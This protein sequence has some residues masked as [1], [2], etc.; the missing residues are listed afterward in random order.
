MI[1]GGAFSGC[2]SLFG[3]LTF[4]ASIT[5]IEESYID[6]SYTGSNFSNCSN[7][8]KVDLSA[9]VD[10]KT[11]AK[12]AF[13]SCRNVETVILPDSL[14][15]I[16]Q[17]A[18][19]SCEK[20]V[21]LN[22]PAGLTSINDNAFNY[23]KSLRV[24]DFSKSVNLTSIGGY[25]FDYCSALETVNVPES[26]NY[27]GSY[28][29]RECRALTNLTVYGKTPA[30]LGEYAFRRVNTDVCAL[31]I[32]TSSF[33]DYLT[34][35]QWGAFVQMR[36][37]I[38][39][40][41]D[42]GAAMTYINNASVNEDD[43]NAMPTTRSSN[44]ADLQGDAVVK[45]G[46]S[47]YVK[48]NETVS[49]FIH[50]EENVMIKQVFFNEE[51]VTAQVVNNVFTT[52]QVEDKSSLRVTLTSSGPIAVQRI[53]LNHEE[54]ILKIAESAQLIATVLP[55]NAT[56]KGVIW[57]SSNEQ[58]A[59]VSESGRV[60]ALKAG[61]A[62]ITAISEEGTVTAS[63]ALTV[64]SN[65]YYFYADDV[66]A[67]VNTSIKMPVSMY[68]ENEVT[69]FQFD[70]YC[71]EGIEITSQW[72]H[73]PLELSY[74]SGMHTVS[75]AKQSNGSVRF[76]IYSKTND[77]FSGNDGVLFYLPLTITDDR[78]SY[79]IELK[80]IHVSGRNAIDFTLPDMTTR[81]IVSEYELGDSNDSKRL[82][83]S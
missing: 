68:N 19:S 81:V 78:G 3:T 18:F 67:F 12:Y 40:M 61:N 75:A 13:S 63:C 77:A 56:N 64:L 15:R 57:T 47:V 53:E 70:A 25:A 79:L 83:K 50:P 76:V 22:F 35:A 60:Q 16:E 36:K 48:K 17:Y 65:N 73:Y 59:T 21:D 80:N 52:P 9:C 74:R 1:G 32:P 44:M 28:A 71:P 66:P 34:A 29:F 55:R 26:V 82:K 7:I 2:S 49:F 39:V 38:D 27:I 6:Y 4:P 30:Q 8:V 58:V 33:Y 14:Q 45:D 62:V 42:E 72:G 23:C 10:L 54:L 41:L 43:E 5:A 46:S 51:D 11:L 37:A 20:L 31:T 69:A 24:A